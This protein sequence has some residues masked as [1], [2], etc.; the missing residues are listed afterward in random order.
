MERLGHQQRRVHM[1]M[2]D[3]QWRSLREIADVTHDPEASISARLRDY[4][5]N[6]YLAQYCVLET[7]RRKGL[8][9]RGVF[10]YQLRPLHG[11]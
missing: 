7:R 5:S 8:E 3:S 4:R 9:E 11:R 10:E 2:Q 1:A 6:E